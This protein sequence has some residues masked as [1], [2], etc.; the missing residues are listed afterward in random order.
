MPGIV[1]TL[2]TITVPPTGQP[3]TIYTPGTAKTAIIGKILIASTWPARE[4]EGY[5]TIHIEQAGT[6]YGEDA[7]CA[8]TRHIKGTT[9]YY[10]YPQ[11]ADVNTSRGT[12]QKGILTT[13]TDVPNTYGKLHQ[14]ANAHNRASWAGA[15]SLF[16]I[17]VNEQ[18]ITTLTQAPR[19]DQILELN[20]GI[21]LTQTQTLQ[22]A[23]GLTDYGA[24][25]YEN[26][27][28]PNDWDGK[29]GSRYDAM[30]A[31]HRAR[32]CSLTITLFGQEH[33]N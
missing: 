22:I 21:P 27:F 15:Y 6:S 10:G 26:D 5:Y 3:I 32:A 13:G 23:N 33:T 11:G 12:T 8:Y 28:R 24:R 2:A 25:Y 16:R 9:W 18:P 4:Q 17:L 20:Q 7:K 31:D 1:K 14:I 19:C 30:I 29:P